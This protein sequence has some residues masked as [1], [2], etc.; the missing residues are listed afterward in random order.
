MLTERQQSLVYSWIVGWV[1][2]AIQ[3]SV[4]MR[5]AADV[6]WV[7]GTVVQARLSEWCMGVE[8][9][10]WVGKQQ[11]RGTA[12]ND[13]G[14]GLHV[15]QRCCRACHTVNRGTSFMASVPWQELEC[16]FVLQGY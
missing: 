9:M 6:V 4:L 14:G 13:F 3:R 15:S 1:G 12:S 7:W 8:E 5:A 2:Q 16:M 11:D 10:M